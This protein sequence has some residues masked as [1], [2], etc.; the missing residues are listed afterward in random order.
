MYLEPKNHFI[1]SFYVIEKKM[2]VFF[3]I[4]DKLYFIYVLSLV[5][6]KRKKKLV[7]HELVHRLSA[8]EENL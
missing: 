5:S 7:K 4:S 8:T 1:Y 2:S 3:I 6:S